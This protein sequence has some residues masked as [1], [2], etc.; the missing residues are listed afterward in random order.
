MSSAENHRARS[1]KSHRVHRSACAGARGYAA[2]AS[3]NKYGGRDA[4]LIYRLQAFRRRIIGQRRK[5]AE[6]AEE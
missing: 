2:A 4:P 6:T 1:H 5:D 3:R